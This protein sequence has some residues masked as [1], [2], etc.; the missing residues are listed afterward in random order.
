M[1]IRVTRKHIK[2]GI[3]QHNCACPI[4]LAVRE[5]LKRDDV[6]VAN[7]RIAIGDGWTDL[8]V[9]AVDFISDFDSGLGRRHLQPFEFELM[10]G[11]ST[12]TER[13]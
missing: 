4:A 10:D 12:T 3:R 7:W 1:K 9:V 11:S 13:S 2:D 6:R 5:T 8:P